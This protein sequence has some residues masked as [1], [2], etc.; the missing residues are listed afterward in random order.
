MNRRTG[1]LAVPAAILLLFL[2]L[3]SAFAQDRDDQDP[4]GRAGRVSYTSG[5]VSFQPGGEGDWLD[6]VSN[7]PLTTGDNLWADRNARAELQFGS[8]SIR[9]GSDS[10]SGSGN[11]THSPVL[12]LKRAILSAICSLTQIRLFLR[13]TVT[14]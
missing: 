2:T 14:E 13:S 9:L 4:P 3:P 7:R 10:E 8:T 12:G 6:V 11:S 5:S 1:F